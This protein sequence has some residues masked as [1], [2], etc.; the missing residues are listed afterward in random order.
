ML[1][2]IV[3]LSTTSVYQVVFFQWK[4]CTLWLQWYTTRNTR[5][6]NILYA[7]RGTKWCM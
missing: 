5:A 4:F 6:A 3:I 7:T 1:F 2:G